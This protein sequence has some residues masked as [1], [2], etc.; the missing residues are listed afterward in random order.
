MMNNV[1][2]AA[3]AKGQLLPILLFFVIII[4]VLKMP[5]AD[6]SR[7]AFSVLA[8]LEKGWLLGYVLTPVAVLGWQWQVRWQRR[9]Y[10]G[11]LREMAKARDDAQ[12]HALPGLLESSTPS[13]QKGKKKR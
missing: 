6:V 5:F 11:R 12:E 8:D 9:K 4:M 2:L 3:L 13:K 10:E 7:L 1:I